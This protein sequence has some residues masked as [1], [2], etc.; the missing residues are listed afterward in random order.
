MGD[1]PGIF[2]PTEPSPSLFQLL[3]FRLPALALCLNGP[4]ASA[5]IPWKQGMVAATQQL[6]G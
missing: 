5:R 1:K 4:E 6:G 2:T 3:R